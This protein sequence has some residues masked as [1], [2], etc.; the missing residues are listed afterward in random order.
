MSALPWGGK[1]KTT[2]DEAVEMIRLGMDLGVIY[3]QSDMV[4]KAVNGFVV[5]LAEA[6]DD[7]TVLADDGHLVAAIGR[8]GC[9][10]PSH[11]S[12][13]AVTMWAVVGK[14]MAPSVV[15][16]SLNTSWAS[17]RNP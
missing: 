4:T 12:V 8:V 17:A 11:G 10:Q 7:G 14:T 15:L 6:V 2:V 1:R 13:D 9:A 3:M 16:W 5:N